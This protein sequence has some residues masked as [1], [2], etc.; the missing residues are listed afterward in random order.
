GQTAWGEPIEE[1]T[2]VTDD[3]GVADFG[4]LAPGNYVAEEVDVDLEKYLP[5]APQS[6]TI[7]GD[8]EDGQIIELNFENKPIDSLEISKQDG[9]TGEELPGAKLLLT[10]KETGEIIDQW[11]S[12]ETPHM[13]SGLEFGRVVIL[14]ETLPPEGF[15]TAS[16]VEITVGSQEKVVMVDELTQ[17]VI[18]KQ[19]AAGSEEL[20]GASLR[21]IDPVTMEVMDEWI[22]GGEPH[23]I[24]GLV[25]GKEYTLIEDQ[26][27]IG[28][29]IAKSI[30]FTVGVDSEVVMVD[31]HVSGV[32]TGDFNYIL[33]LFVLA[34]LAAGVMAAA[35]IRRRWRR[36]A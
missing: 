25:E 15:A 14:R 33:P 21:V 26:A 23:M 8:E 20:E 9:T 10:D 2:V 5:V 12:T 17:V 30:N 31:E 36:D 29:R 7:T 35:A 16:E 1:K 13:V 24:E 18:S 4:Q 11:T 27:P 19:D 3:E 32:E 22:S 6:F 28:Y 34:V